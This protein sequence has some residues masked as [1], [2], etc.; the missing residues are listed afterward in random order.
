[1]GKSYVENSL[2]R[3]LKRKVKITLGLVVT[4]MITGAVALGIE[5]GSTEW[6]KQQAKEWLSGKG[7]EVNLTEELKAEGVVVNSDKKG[8][9][10]INFADKEI[11]VAKENISTKTANVLQNS[12]NLLSN[13]KVNEKE[14]I[15]YTDGI[16]LTNVGETIE[17]TQENRNQIVISGKGNVFVN[18]GTLNKEQVAESGAVVVNKG[19]IANQNDYGQNI[20]SGIGYNY[21]K[22]SNN[23]KWGQ[24]V[25]E[26]GTIYNY[27][28]IENNGDNGQMVTDGAAYNYGVITNAGEY[29]QNVLSGTGYNYGIIANKKGYGQYAKGTIINYGVI[30]NKS[31]FGQYIL[32]NGI[33]YGI[34]MN[35]G[36]YGQ[37]IAS[38]GIGINYGVIANKNNAGQWI[39]A[40]GTGINYGII[41]N[42]ANEGQQ[43]DID[44]IGANYGII[45][46]KGMNAQY[47]SGTGIN[48][49]EIKNTGSSG[50]YI[51]KEG[52]GIN[53]G[54]IANTGGEGQNIVSGTGYNYGLIANKGNNGQYIQNGVGVNYGVIKNTGSWAMNALGNSQGKNFG[55]VY[56]KDSAVFNGNIEN[57]GIVIT[58]FPW[59][60]AIGKGK[61][62]GVVLNTKY[63]LIPAKDSKIN[64]HVTDLTTGNNNIDGAENKTYYT[65]NNT[66]EFD[67]D[68]TNNHLISVITNKNQTAFKYTGQKDL[69]LKD[70]TITGFFTDGGTGTL[71][72]A[73]AGKNLSVINSQI[74]AVT[75]KGNS[76]DILTVK[77]DGGKVT[78]AGTAEITGKIEGNGAVEFVS[79]QNK[80]HDVSINGDVILTNDKGQYN[81]AKTNTDTSFNII[82][83]NNFIMD[84]TNDKNTEINNIVLGNK[85]ELG[86]IDGSKSTERISL[87]LKNIEKI[88]NITLGQNDDKL[89]VTNTK[90]K[91]NIDLGNGTDEFIVKMGETNDS[92]Y[93]KETGNTFD[94]KM[95]GIEKIVLEGTGSAKEG[96]YIGENAE[97]LSKQTKANNQGTELEVKKSTLYVEMNNNYGTNQTTTSL[98]KLAGTN[99][100]NNLTVTT[101]DKGNI[102]FIVGDKFDVSKQQ[103]TVAEKYKV[104]GTL[105]SAVI[106]KGTGKDGAVE[107]KD[108]KVNLILKSAD[109]LGLS[110]YKNIY[111]AT[112]QGLSQDKDLRDAINYNDKIKLQNMIKN[113][114][115]IAEAFFTTGYAVTKDITDTYMSVVDDFGRK[116]GKGE[117]IA[118]G[119]YVNSDTEFDGG[120]DSKGYD[121]DITGTVGMLE[122]GLTDSTSYGAVY[123]QG[124]TEVDIQNGGKFEG[125]NRYVGMF[126]KHKAQNGINLVG[127]IGYTKNDLDLK[128]ATK[129]GNYH[130]I[131]D[132]EANSDAI[133]LGLK[134]T[135]NYKISD[136]LILQPMA[137][138]RYSFINQDEVESSNANFKME[139]QETK[140]LEGMVGAN[141]IKSFNIYS[142]ILSLKAGA[143]FVMTEVSM[144]DDRN[145]TLYGKGIQVLNEQEIADSR[146]EGHIGIDYEHESG[147]GVDAKYEMIWTDKGDNSRVTAGISYRF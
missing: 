105:S 75:D 100:E 58:T 6:H 116:A 27:G 38:G 88:G 85:A 53:Y 4:F 66:K 89:T 112:L 14:I 78:E 43:I 130:M 114:G 51:L 60:N 92:V 29:G 59:V 65:L 135:K 54:T 79:S 142:G 128:L 80:N 122:Y 17:R 71:L 125:D 103:I 145:Y 104:S 49:G 16:N 86:V 133:T 132:G 7:T 62:N 123:G 34:I 118:Y 113:T 45:E 33:N 55:V 10:K 72:E 91:G 70:T 68:L 57:N 36:A 19:K 82:K 99:G 115:Y 74:N 44:G 32:G 8:G 48:Y 141:V 12:L 102:K 67:K 126:I 63:N 56:A 23:G 39:R 146:I 110:E 11:V 107:E 26:K 40:N 20:Q 87:E 13:K 121:G 30:A 90:Y 101:G 136:N 21:G 77:L 15:G 108:G 83:A 35:E 31:S 37:H 5:E 24:N 137:G 93:L 119:K 117:W 139:E 47:I 42:K 111:S 140:I 84:F 109:E 52:L 61:N 98:D 138:I 143:K 28:V 2:K 97:I 41:M 131:S 73:G 106:F 129:A 95:T 18:N 120:K 9:I 1:M 76:E 64:S 46:N 22:I 127:N 96:W 94:Y 25:D 134:G 81:L 50:Q 144:A 124:D 69:I 147:V 3:F